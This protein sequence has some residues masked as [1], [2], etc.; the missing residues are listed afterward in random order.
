[1]NTAD[2]QLEHERFRAE[3]LAR[4][5]SMVGEKWPKGET[6]IGAWDERGCALYVLDER[7]I[8]TR[9]VLVP[10]R[11]ALIPEEVPA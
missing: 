8:V 7:G 10:P 2:I 5:K 9:Q 1:M 6:F 4:L 11:H 3:R